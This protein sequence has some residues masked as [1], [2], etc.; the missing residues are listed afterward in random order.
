M[1]LRLHPEGSTKG[2][3]L[4]YVIV[5]ALALFANG[6]S[7]RTFVGLVWKR[8]KDENRSGSEDYAFWVASVMVASR[9]RSATFARRAL[10]AVGGVCQ[11]QPRHDFHFQL[12]RR[13]STALTLCL[14]P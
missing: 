12:R 5:L 1:A 4:M 7:E 13:I 11:S 14:M 8:L 2:G 3:V 6:T 10:S 9:G